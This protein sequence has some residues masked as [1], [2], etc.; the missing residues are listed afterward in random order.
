M[1]FGVM[2]YFCTSELFYFTQARGAS[3]WFTCRAVVLLKNIDINMLFV[4]GCFL[5]FVLNSVVS[6]EDLNSTMSQATAL[7]KLICSFF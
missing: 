6:D 1:V 5:V 7:C 2:N 3:L 4:F